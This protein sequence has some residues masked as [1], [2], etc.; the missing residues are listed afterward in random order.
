MLGLPDDVWVHIV[1]YLPNARNVVALT[2]CRTLWRKKASWTQRVQGLTLTSDAHGGICTSPWVVGMCDKIH[3]TIPDVQQLRDLLPVELVIRYTWNKERYGMTFGHH[4]H[5]HSTIKAFC[6]RARRGLVRYLDSILFFSLLVHRDTRI[7]WDHIREIRIEHLHLDKTYHRHDVSRMARVLGGAS[8]R[9]M[10]KNLRELEG[11]CVPRYHECFSHLRHL[12]RA[13]SKGKLPSLVVLQSGMCTCDD[14]CRTETLNLL[15]LI[16][17]R[18][19]CPL[20]ATLDLTPLLGRPRT[21]VDQYTTSYDLSAWTTPITNT[22]SKYPCRLH[23]M[24]FLFYEHGIQ[25]G[26]ADAQWLLRVAEDDFPRQLS[27]ELLYYHDDA[28]NAMLL[29]KLARQ[30]HLQHLFLSVHPDQPGLGE[31]LERLLASPALREL[32]VLLKPSIL[33]G[34]EDLFRHVR[35]GFQK[36]RCILRLAL[37]SHL[38]H[39]Y[40]AL[41]S[42]QSLGKLVRHVVN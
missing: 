14:I 34:G 42:I 25:S 37:P 24:P 32:E 4:C 22:L 36:S 20:L 18:R 16:L 7:S 17:S 28:I 10:D 3:F 21:L 5:V 33:T 15:H 19:S 11:A 2:L 1:R 9:S 39:V 8:R 27:V 35:D 6:A 30:P 31:C 13:M 41:A 26:N 40:H 38:S 23:S 29:D 12:L